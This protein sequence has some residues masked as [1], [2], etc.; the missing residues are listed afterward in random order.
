MTSGRRRAA[1]A[2]D[3]QVLHLSAANQRQWDDFEAT[4]RR[5]RQQWL[6]DHPHDDRAPDVQDTL[7]AQLK[8]YVEVSGASSASATSCSS[9]KHP[10]SRR[11]LW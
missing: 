7:D 11:C 8:E 6:L 2:A 5:G 9:G 3:W 1:R 10:L 4:R